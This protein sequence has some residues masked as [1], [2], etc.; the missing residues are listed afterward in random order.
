MDHCPP[1]LLLL[2]WRSKQ[3]IVN[4]CLLALWG[5]LCQRLSTGTLG[6]SYILT[7]GYLASPTVELSRMITC[8]RG[9]HLDS[10]GCPV[11][12]LITVE[13]PLLLGGVLAG[14]I[15]LPHMPHLPLLGQCW[16]CNHESHP[17]VGHL[18]T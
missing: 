12:D 11:A 10:M 17:R 14:V 16:G 9:T 13:Q 7:G 3:C 5:V 6:C 1:K 4:D 8:P 2:L 18:I 15:E